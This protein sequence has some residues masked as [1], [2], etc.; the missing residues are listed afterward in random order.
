MKS[1]VDNGMLQYIYIHPIFFVIKVYG[2]EDYQE[3][4]ARLAV[5]GSSLLVDVLA[6]IEP[7]LK[8]AKVP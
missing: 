2:T 1:K 6:N 3:L 4:S 7:K 8:D 5:L